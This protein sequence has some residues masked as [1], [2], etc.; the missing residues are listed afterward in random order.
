[1]RADLT[2]NF[3]KNVFA[4]TCTRSQKFDG[5]CWPSPASSGLLLKPSGLSLRSSQLSLR[6][7]WL[8][9]GSS[10]L[11]SRSSWLSLRS[12]GFPFA[13]MHECGQWMFHLYITLYNSQNS[14]IV[15][16]ECLMKTEKTVFQI[17]SCELEIV[18]VENSL[19]SGITVLEFF[20]CSFFI[21]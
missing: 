7:S 12:S 2:S 16:V 18:F 8:L 19:C 6:S 10:G 5:Q 1:M 21:K 3:N 11:S 9:L 20:P 15:R 14:F 17:Q 4:G 13:S